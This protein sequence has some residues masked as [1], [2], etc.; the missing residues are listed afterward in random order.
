MSKIDWLETQTEYQPSGDET[1]QAWM[2]L[3]RHH[4]A[5]NIPDT[6]YSRCEAR[7]KHLESL[8][9]P[10]SVT[11][12]SLLIPIM[13]RDLVPAASLAA[14][15]TPF[16][17]H[18]AQW[19]TRLLYYEP[20][21]P[22]RR[23]GTRSQHPERLRRFFAYSYNDPELGLIIVADRMAGLKLLNTLDTAEQQAWAHE[24]IGVHL[25][26]L[27]MIGLW[28]FRRELGNISLEIVNPPFY[29]QLER[30][31]AQYQE[32]HQ[33][34]F[35]QIQTILNP[36][37]TSE[38]IAN[39]IVSLHD[40]TP[41]SVY[42]RMERARRRGGKFTT[43]DASLPVIDVV[44]ETLRDCYH[45]LGI[46]HNTW[47]PA[48]RHAS[49]ADRRFYDYIAAPRYNGYRCLI[50]TVICELDRPI[51]DDTEEKTDIRA[52]QRLVE[53]RIRT[54]EME[55]INMQGVAA[56][57]RSGSATQQVA[58][59]G[60][61]WQNT[62]IRDVIKPG[63][64]DQL[65][66]LTPIGV[67]TPSGEVIYPVRKGSTMVDMAFRIHAQLGPFARRF[68]V[69]GRQVGFEYELNH[70]D[71]IEIEY[72]PQFP[73][74][75]AEWGNFAITSVARS[76]IRRFLRDV[77]LIPHKGR[78]R[79]DEV[80][81]REFRIYGMRFSDEKIEESLNRLAQKYHFPSVEG[82]YMRVLEGE[83][84]ADEIVSSMIE[85][86]LVSHI[87]PQTGDS[88]PIHKMQLCRCWMQESESRKYDPSTRV[89][90]GT[91]IVGRVMGQDKNALLVI[92]R[93]DCRNAP[94]DESAIALRWRNS[95]LPREVAEITITAPPRS[96]VVG[97]VLKAVY[98]VNKDDEQNS[99]VIHR[100][101]SEMQDGSLSMSL[102]V[103]APTL[104]DLETLQ[105]ALRVIQRGRYITDFKMWQLFP[106]QKVAIAGRSDKRRVNPYTLRQVRDQSMFFGRSLEIKNIVDSIGEGGNFIVLY[107][108]KRIGKTSLLYQLAE[109]LLPESCDVLPI[110]FDAHSLSTF[111]PIAFLMG[112]VEATQRKLPSQLKHWDDR[113]GLQIRERDLTAEPFTRFAQWVKRV[114]GRLGGTRLVFMID[115]FTRA[116]EE[117]RKGKLDISFFDGLQ[118]LVGSEDVSFIL[119]VHDF[120]YTEGSLSW[121]MFQR[122]QPVRL[123]ALDREPAA[124]LVRQPLERLY[125][126]DEQLV[127]DILNLTDCHP[128]FIQAICQALTTHMAQKA[129]DRITPGDL[130]R[131][132][133]AV[134]ITGDHY[135]S[136][137]RSLTD[138]QSWDTLKI[139]AFLTDEEHP[140]ATSDEIRQGLTRFGHER[141][142]WMI[143]KS[144]GDLVHSGIIE[145]RDV[146]RHAA[147]RIPVGMFRKWL[148]QVVTHPIVSR[149]IQRR[150]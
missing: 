19:A 82:L 89:T 84:S 83:L 40:T 106:G 100:A 134:L 37:L 85:A 38:G 149:D 87:E 135:F 12:A 91:P 141:D 94:H 145:A 51:G 136:H 73:S 46:V 48:H 114:E 39:T 22:K 74:L 101:Q 116:E 6:A 27:E 147:Y 7:T 127:E 70:R 148:R 31:V 52:A 50:T 8:G 69:N 24:T 3:N 80:L 11:A 98:E 36:L 68:W 128:Y 102:V 20:T 119:C 122:G 23:A 109:N 125:Q 117:C 137:Y 47:Q 138:E 81:T 57:L 93:A 78:Q 86:E 71:L 26:L 64:T 43:D 97:M 104:A 55:A 45:A 59:T 77:D 33:T 34:L 126:F 28:E 118:Y 129:D 18:N 99:L 131:A 139:L 16:T 62:A 17:I 111:S 130:D 15:F 92:H 75:T 95:G 103:D 88:W 49:Y 132:T 142:S 54:V 53:F 61:W 29:R 108:Q 107:G 150:D 30:H 124:R 67:F 4:T 123:R 5:G 113:K 115:E 10:S 96:Y 41:I 25:P 21:D 120:V 143:A 65:Q 76:H 105:N 144:I 58:L 72:D 121:E 44:V 63:M 42:Q 79:I 66:H 133:T 56:V 112:L 146:Q 32:R 2:L 140:W 90:P 9:L 1:A 14:Q 60:A 35:N 13:R 110:L